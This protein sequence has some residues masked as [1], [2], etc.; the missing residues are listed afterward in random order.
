MSEE[1]MRVGANL[2][3][4]ETY[5]G[6]QPVYMG[7]QTAC[8]QHRGYSFT[9]CC[10]GIPMNALKVGHKESTL[11]RDDILLEQRYLL[12]I[13]ILIGRSLSYTNTGLE[14]PWSLVPYL[15]QQFLFA[16]HSL[17]QL[18]GVLKEQLCQRHW[19]L[20]LSCR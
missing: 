18:L 5:M 19:P 1:T 9:R 8:V 7:N 3:G 6:N 13:K 17:P 2:S 20:P 15:L 16:V 4:C 10:K 11:T 14:S 12:S